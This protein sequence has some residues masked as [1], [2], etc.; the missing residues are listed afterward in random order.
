MA[1]SS[2]CGLSQGA[3]DVAGFINRLLVH[4]LVDPM[5]WGSG[6]RQ[7]IVLLLLLLLLLLLQQ[8]QFKP[9]RP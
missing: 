6:H 3:A 8:Q 1:L 7:V 4:V 9:S 2:A 5:G